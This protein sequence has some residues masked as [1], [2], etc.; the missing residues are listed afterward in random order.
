[1]SRKLVM[2]VA[3]HEYPTFCICGEN[4]GNWPGGAMQWV[5]TGTPPDVRMEYRS[6]LDVKIDHFMARHPRRLA[7]GLIC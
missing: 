1:M 6:F 5:V 3:Y 4:L 7:M 2:L